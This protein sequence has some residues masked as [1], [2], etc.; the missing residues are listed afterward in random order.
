MSVGRMW[1][2]GNAKEYKGVS[3]AYIDHEI[4]MAHFILRQATLFVI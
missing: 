4:S 2:K 3:D 1:S